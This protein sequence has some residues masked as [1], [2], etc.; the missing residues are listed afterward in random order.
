MKEITCIQDE[1]DPKRDSV[2]VLGF[3]VVN[4]ESLEW[5]L[6]RKDTFAYLGVLDYAKS[7]N[8]IFIV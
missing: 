6:L 1:P 3:W 4:L 7:T 8:L 5:Y 2:F